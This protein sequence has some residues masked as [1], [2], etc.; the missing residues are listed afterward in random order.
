MTSL[1]LWP[2]AA[3]RY[4]VE[5]DHLFIGLLIVTGLTAGL[6]FVLLIVFG[7]R[8]RHTNAVE[9]GDRVKKSWHW[10]IG[11]TAAT[12]AG[13]LGLFVWAADL[14]ARLYQPPAGSI[15]IFVTG[16]RWMWKIEHAGGQREIDELHIP[17]GRPIRLV[18]TSED[19]IHSFY[20]PAFRVKHD[21]VP[22]RYQEL[23]FSADETGDFALFCAE[24]CGTDHAH[25]GGHVVVL[26]AAGFEDWLRRQPTPGAV[27]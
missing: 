12:M 8:Y 17:V 20:L 9:R 13:F 11:W 1:P 23:W 6:V 26:T 10:E 27:K 14:Y 24:F 18:M 2:D 3:S 7:T 16:K 15:E 21:V 4:A 25:M 5:T 19:V 22:G